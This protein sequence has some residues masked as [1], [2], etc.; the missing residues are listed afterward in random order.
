VGPVLEANE[1]GRAILTALKER[2]GELE[3]VDRGSYLRVLAPSPC[4]ITRAAVERILGRPFRLP[5]DLEAVMPSFRGK[6]ALGE[7]E[8]VWS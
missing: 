2:H 1:V 5:S 3:V 6:L 4:G 8:A 7:D